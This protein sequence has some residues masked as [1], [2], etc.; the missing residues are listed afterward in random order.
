[1][2]RFLI[3]ISLIGYVLF[4]IGSLFFR[5]GAASQQGRFQARKPSQGSIHINTPPKEKKSG[6]IKGGD[7]V[8]YEEVK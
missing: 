5:A 3:I 8:D 6:T 1:M 2:L 4:K 7:Y